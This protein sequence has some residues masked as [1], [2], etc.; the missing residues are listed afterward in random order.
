MLP[1]VEGSVIY[2][3][4]QP[5]VNSCEE[6]ERRGESLTLQFFYNSNLVTVVNFRL[7]AI[8]ACLISQTVCGYQT[9]HKDSSTERS[10]SKRS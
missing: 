2:H 3:N 6:E 10:V 7:T 4:A 8:K 5:A 1:T 9:I